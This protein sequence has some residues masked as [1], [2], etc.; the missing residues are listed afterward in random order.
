M[1][2][3]EERREREG[4]S[5]AI[6]TSLTIVFTTN[7]ITEFFME[8]TQMGI[9]ACTRQALDDEGISKVADL[10]LWEEDERY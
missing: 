7:Q 3:E 5:H 2:H 4:G 10:H 6:T 9:S 1:R 8:A